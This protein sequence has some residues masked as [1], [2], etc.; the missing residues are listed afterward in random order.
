MSEHSPLHDA[1]AQA[2]AVFTEIAGWSMPL[3]YGDPKAEYRLAREG[4]ALFDLSH[5]GKVEVIGPEAATYL[6]NLVTNDIKNLPYSDGCE[7]FLCN[8][9]ARV[10]AYALVY[11]LKVFDD[12]AFV[13]SHAAYW[14]DVDPGFGD[15]VL[16]HLDR[17]LISEQVELAD[18]TAAFAQLHLAGPGA[19]A[20]IEQ[21]GISG[22]SGHQL[23]QN[24]FG[25]D[26]VQFRRN[27]RLGVPGFD[28]VCPAAAATGYWHRYLERGARPAGLA[29][30]EILRLEA[31][32]PVYGRDITEN[33]LAP[34]IGRTAQAISYTKGCYLGQEPI[35]RLRD[36]G[37][38]NRVLTGLR[39]EGSDPVPDGARLWR[40]G[41]EAG[42]VTSSVYS[43]GI[44]TAIALAYV[45]RGSTDAG[46]VLEVETPA[47][48]RRAEVAS[49][50]LRV[51]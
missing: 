19:P 29:A 28:I 21:D 43:P 9:Q 11:C 2:G 27:D 24:G 37:H 42:Q 14:L 30:E 44:G 46:T 31:G 32:T 6:H 41:K 26:T 45:R 12:V 16:R 49:L 51:P 18:R 3:R 25:P 13:S 34:E 1:T 33:N 15:K 40:D 20:L 39:I 10:L 5:R 7:A 36:L 35:V 22:L 17:H 48:R 23:M 38:A 8:V 47:Q 4:A 50:P